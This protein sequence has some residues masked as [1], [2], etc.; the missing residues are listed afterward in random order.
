MLTALQLQQQ[1]RRRPVPSL[2][3]QY[4]AYILQ[5]IESYK[6][7]LPR[8]ALLDL[9][10]EAM[11]EMEAARGEQL[12]L[13][14]VLVAE[15]VDRLIRKRLSLQ[16]YSRWSRQFRK[17]RQAQ[18]EPTRWG[19]DRR[20]PL[21]GLLPRLEP[22]D[23]AIVVGQ[24]AAP[25]A[26]LLA[27]H[28]VRVTFLGSDMTFVDQVESRITEE[29]LGYYCETYVAPTGHFPPETP[30]EV[31]IVVIDTATLDR[32]TPP[33]RR[34]ILEALRDR[35]IPGGVHVILPS[36]QALAPEAYLS[37]Y[38]DWIRE[39][40]PRGRRQA[41]RSLGVLLSRPP[42]E[43]AAEQVSERPATSRDV[44]A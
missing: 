38:G 16:P 39:D 43:R 42:E 41:A 29:A 37:H 36:E 26:C 3:Q 40:A 30:A 31:P 27:A 15:W 32:E 13:T 10:D 34:A 23:T 19:I 18:R 8:H 25:A 28:D 20:S 1:R 9:G 6:N 17:L 24:D 14:E 33:A 4:E 35:T 5:R 22:G 44:P 11:A 2:K 12:L 7:S 21:A